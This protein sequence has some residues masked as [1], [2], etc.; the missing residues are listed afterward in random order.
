M[1]NTNF[2]IRS[3]FPAILISAF[4]LLS[5]ACDKRKVNYIFVLDLTESVS[6]EARER[7]FA[8][9]KLRAKLLKRGD[10]LTVIPLNADSQTDTSGRILRLKTSEKREL[11]DADLEEFFELADR[12]ISQMAINSES[13]R[14]SD[15][16]GALRVVR[17]EISLQNKAKNRIVVIVLSDMVHSTAQIRFETDRNFA[18]PETAR[19]FATNTYQNEKFDFN[20][21]DIYIG[22]LESSDWRKMSTERRAAVREYWQEYFSKGKAGTIHFATDGTGQ[23]EKFLAEASKTNFKEAS[24]TNF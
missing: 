1:T 13:Y 3:K 19:R 9:I 23:L 16:L 17:E 20:K 10:S 18:N 2:K 14:Q 8:A 5:V 4:L 7:S 15:V 21:S 22:F 11:A 24:K 6:L 12:Q